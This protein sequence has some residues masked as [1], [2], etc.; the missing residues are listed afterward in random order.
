MLCSDGDEL[1]QNVYVNCAVAKDGK[2]TVKQLEACHD[3]FE[4]EKASL[5]KRIKE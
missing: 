4:N 3:N 2:I 1:C 5:S